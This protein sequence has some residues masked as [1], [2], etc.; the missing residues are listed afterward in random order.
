M[1]N[2]KGSGSLDVSTGAP[3]LPDDGLQRA[4]NVGLDTKGHITL[5]RGSYKLGVVAT[6]SA[7]E[8]FDF[9]IEQGGDRYYFASDGSIYKNESLTEELYDSN[10]L[11]L[12]DVNGVQFMVIS[13]DSV[14]EL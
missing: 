3:Q 1:I 9:M 11:L 5:R 12:S 13:E 2:F 6:S 7:K 14:N 10:G 8:I 4:K